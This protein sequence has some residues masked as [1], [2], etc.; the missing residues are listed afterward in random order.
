MNGI[1]TKTKIIFAVMIV[2]PIIILLIIPMFTTDKTQA[3]RTTAHEEIKALEIDPSDSRLNEV[4]GC[5][6]DKK[7][8]LGVSQ[9]CGVTIKLTIEKR[10]KAA[11]RNKADA[12]NWERVELSNI[13]KDHFIKREQKCDLF[14]GSDDISSSTAELQINCN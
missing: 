2:A 7:F 10:E 1:S 8:D 3:I 14:L 4:N 5:G 11:Y 6:E 13:K 9:A 12:A